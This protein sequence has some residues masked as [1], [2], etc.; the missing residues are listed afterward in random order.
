MAR[1]P[2]RNPSDGFPCTHRP[3]VSKNKA[4]KRIR[5]AQGANAMKLAALTA[6]LA[7]VL[8]FGL[9]RASASPHAHRSL[10]DRR[11]HPSPEPVQPSDSREAVILLHGLGLNRF[12]MLRLASALRRDGYRVVNLSYASRQVPLE[13]LASDWLPAM[14]RAQNL[15]TVPHVHFV[16]HSMGGI[17]LR[18][19][20]REHTLPRLGRIV[21]LAPP[22]HGSEIAD[23]LS[24]NALFR[25]FTGVNGHRLGTRAD[26]VPRQLGPLDADLGIIAGDRSLNPLFSAWIGRPNDGKVSVESTRLDGMRDHLV[27][28]I[29]HTWMQWNN[30]VISE[31]KFFLREGKFQR[32]PL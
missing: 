20:L 9:S 29:S 8:T 11:A 6:G 30:R 1:T 10:S 23:H 21:M 4:F 18:L 3:G 16:T 22:N 31:V 2:F 25:L 5:F 32:P 13:Q 24:D 19:Y 27:V 7:L 17:L 14:L 28:P 15:D 12:A 26:S